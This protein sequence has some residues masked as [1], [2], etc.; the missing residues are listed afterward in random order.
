MSFELSQQ[1]YEIEDELRV[2]GI[3]EERT[4]WS[5]E[6]TK[7]SKYAPDLE[8]HDWGDDPRQPSDRELSGF[9]EIEVAHDDSDWQ[10]GDVPANWTTINFLRRKVVE[11]NYDVGGWRDL[12]DSARR[13]VYLKFNHNID[14]CFVAPVERVFHD[15]N[16]QSYRDGG[17][18][19]EFYCLPPNHDSITYGIHDSIQF[20]ESYFDQ[21]EDNQTSLSQ[22]GRRNGGGR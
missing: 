3:L 14:N 12:K 2:R 16:I 4:D 22:F 1:S 21:L 5:F 15:G 19:W 20:I 9:I 17:P 6:F 13:T 18:N 8:L 10:S 11:Y 7:N